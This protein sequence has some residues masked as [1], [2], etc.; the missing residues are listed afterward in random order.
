MESSSSEEFDFSTDDSGEERLRE[1]EEKVKAMRQ[2]VRRPR[3]QTTSTQPQA[4]QDQVKDVEEKPESGKSGKESVDEP[5]GVT[6]SDSSKRPKAKSAQPKREI[7]SADS[8]SEDEP[9]VSVRKRAEAH[10]KVES[11][12]TPKTVKKTKHKK[13]SAKRQ[14]SP[15][16]TAGHESTEHEER[17]RRQDPTG[18]SEIREHRAPETTLL[19]AVL[20]E[21]RSQEYHARDSGVTEAKSPDPGRVECTE[22][23]YESSTSSESSSDGTSSNTEGGSSSHNTPNVGTPEAALE[24]ESCSPKDAQSPSE[25]EPIL[26]DLMMSDDSPNPKCTLEIKAT[27]EFAVAKPRSKSPPLV[28]PKLSPRSHR[29][30]VRTPPNVRQ[31]MQLVLPAPHIK[32]DK[33]AVLE[34]YLNGDES[35][36]PLVHQ[37]RKQ[38]LQVFMNM[39]KKKSDTLSHTC[40]VLPPCD[41]KRPLVIEKNPTVE[42]HTID[43]RSIPDFA[44]TSHPHPS[45]D[46]DE[47]EEQTSEPL[48]LD[49]NPQISE[50][51]ELDENPQTSAPTKPQASMPFEADE[52]S[53]ASMP[54]E[55]DEEPA[56]EITIENTGL[57]AH[58]VTDIASTLGK[59]N[60]IARSLSSRHEIEE[61]DGFYATS[62]AVSMVVT[63]IAEP[64]FP[65]REPAPPPPRARTV[66]TARSTRRDTNTTPWNRD[67]FL[68]DRPRSVRFKRSKKREP[69]LESSLRASIIIKRLVRPTYT[70]PTDPSRRVRIIH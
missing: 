42:L 1:N 35:L 15:E 25:E 22:M 49:E 19:D 2:R 44:A 39:I 46:E 61:S 60:S 58:L 67:A 69:S 20:G 21:H 36:A 17:E 16:S 33:R 68:R 24:T 70:R 14:R 40:P 10:V 45:G 13:H 53:Q 55:A 51:L 26:R 8:T 41:Y 11:S 3:P 6:R 31:Q 38:E 48:E 50:P 57:D 34:R 56:T 18:D 5:H 28:L 37:I 23:P 32:L 4:T 29:K 27:D 52:D 54:F 62:Q 63:N 47:E 65:V 59:V 12:N 66:R 30:R 43:M 64:E 7:A 9:K